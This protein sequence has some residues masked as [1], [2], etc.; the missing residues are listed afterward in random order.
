MKTLVFSAAALAC[1]LFADV[2]SL[3]ISFD[4]L[5]HKGMCS[6]WVNHKG[7]SFQPPPNVSIKKENG[8]VVVHFSDIKGKNGF[9]WSTIGR[10]PAVCGDKVVV[11]A[12]V[13]GRGTFSFGIQTLDKNKRWTR[14]IR[15][16]G[17]TL[18]SEWK[19]VVA[20]MPIHNA[21]RSETGFF[22]IDFNAVKGSELYITEIKAD[23]YRYSKQ[24]E[25]KDHFVPVPVYCRSNGET[26]LSE[27]RFFFDNQ[28]G[29][30]ETVLNWM[31][32]GMK[33]ILGWERSFSEKNAVKI[34]FLPLTGKNYPS[35]EYYEL[36]IEKNGIAIRAA[37]REGFFTGSGRFMGIIES[38]LIKPVPEKGF[39]FPLVEI[40]D[41]PAI[42]VR[43]FMIHIS[44][45]ST[46]IKT[47]EEWRKHFYRYIDVAAMLGYNAVFINFGGRMELK[48]HPELVWR[49]FRFHTQEEIKKM[50]A[51]ASGIGM[52]VY[53]MTSVI[54]HYN[55]GYQIFPLRQ[56]NARNINGVLVKAAAMNVGHPDFYKILFEVFDEIF[57]VFDNPEY[58]MIRSDEFYTETPML[59]KYTGKKCIDFYSEV[60]NKTAEHAAKRGVKIITCQDM[61][62]PALTPGEESNGPKDAEKL[63]DMVDKNV[64][65]CYWRYDFSP[66]AW[67]K[68]FYEKG[69]HDLWVMPW[70]K[71][72][73]TRLLIAEGYK[74][75]AKVFAGVWSEPGQN[76]GLSAIAEYAWNP[77]A[78]SFQMDR[79]DNH[80]DQMFY[81][82]G[83]K[84]PAKDS[85]FA[86]PV[87]GIPADHAD[88][89]TLQTL[90]K[91]D[92][93]VPVDFSKA[94]RFNGKPGYEKVS[95]T[96]DLIALYQSGELK[97]YSFGV[98]GCPQRI[99]FRNPVLNNK[100]G[101]K[102]L[103]IYTSAFGKSTRTNL[104]GSEFAIKGDTIE[105]VDCR[106]CDPAGTPTIGN[107]PIFNDALTL[108]RHSLNFY[109]EPRHYYRNSNMLIGKLKKGTKL[110][111]Y[112]KV[113]GVPPSGKISYQLSGKRY[114]AVLYLQAAGHIANF[115]PAAVVIVK[116]KDGKTIRDVVNSYRWHISGYNY[117]K[118]LHYYFPWQ[119]ELRKAD[120]GPVIA[121]EYF[122]DSPLT[123]LEI[124]PGKIAA[125]TGL[126]ILGVTEYRTAKP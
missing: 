41:H 1:S 80:S 82:R 26:V 13:K 119:E 123:S 39:I 106:F 78:K 51:Y 4:K 29:V 2:Q 63:L 88:L 50:I 3:K 31:A 89:N 121:I 94:V 21:G 6:S 71:P 14:S 47:I 54:G 102:E 95:G 20:D 117:Q 42:P 105:L 24:A 90:C 61:W 62:V 49:N 43:S 12:K 57:D 84:I 81:S 37:A 101:T 44:S 96:P 120:A 9:L 56:D 107:F 125:D 112:K 46:P 19:T 45:A 73:P 60:L 36:N 97:S 5:N 118:N 115:G 18:T 32:S 113:P 23:L 99:S 104:Y 15:D 27:P 22:L 116:T 8:K 34:S 58:I 66:F 93:G 103:V 87:G 64:S 25:F 111:F 98:K 10:F 83:N 59:E 100:R 65:I 67:L 108:S 92:S 11:T 48:K 114:R 122:S 79:L 33:R 53:P 74:Y 110:E 85:L 7:A 77:H 40:K 30:P 75:G 17:I 68:K 86:V 91:N 38:K 72:E 52:K 35:K 16:S 124:I 109:D 69:F 70:Y 55:G 126:I 28:G 76:N